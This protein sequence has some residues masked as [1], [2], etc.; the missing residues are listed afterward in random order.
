M[1]RLLFCLA[2][3]E[4]EE[5]PVLGSGAVGLDGAVGLGRDVLAVEGLDGDLLLGDLLDGEDLPVV[6]LVAVALE[7]AVGLGREEL[8][9]VGLEGESTVLAKIRLDTHF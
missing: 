7:G 3:G 6:D 8:A 4:G 2:L 1:L 9:V 5:L